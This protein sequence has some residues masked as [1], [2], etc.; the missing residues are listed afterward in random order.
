MDDRKII[1]PQKGPQEDFLRC[2]ADGC[3]FGGSAFGG[4]SYAILIESLRYINDPH[5]TGIIFRRKSTE[6]TTPG[7][8]WDTAQNIY[9]SINI[10]AEMTNHNLTATFP[11][12]AKIK[13]SHLEHETNKFDHHGGQ[14][15]FIGFDELTTFTRSQF[16]YLLTRNR[17][18]DGCNKRPYWRATCNPD[19]DSWVR[20]LIS[21]W[22]DDDT[23]YADKE[24]SGILRHYTILD[25]QIIWVDAYWRDEGGLSPRSLTFIPSSIK[26]NPAGMKADP[27]YEAN[28]RAQDNVTRERLLYGNWNISYRGGMFRQ[29]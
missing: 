22:I 17:P 2:P 4:K 14:Y 7:G 13:F 20:E 15:C 3:V 25:D 27:N 5:Y 29:D 6:I 9:S 1:K 26:D 18:A 12:G 8:L 21:W 10:K 28:L 16:F 11:S 23:G 19:A 24:L